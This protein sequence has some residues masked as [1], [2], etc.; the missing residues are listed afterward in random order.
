MILA[1]DVGGT[2]TLLGLFERGPHRPTRTAVGSFPTA[3]FGSLGDI[4]SAFL[5]AEGRSAD[6]LEGACFGVAGPVVEGRAV[7]TNVG[8]AVMDADLRGGLGLDRVRLLND[9]EAT[10]WSLPVLAPLEFETLQDG[11]P[12]PHGNLAIIAAG[13]GLG[14]AIVLRQGETYQPIASEG[15]HADFAPATEREMAL[16]ESLNVG[17][18]RVQWEDI[19]SGRGLVTLHRFT[20][21]RPCAAVTT[22]LDAEIAPAAISAAA[23]AHRCAACVEAL[24][25][26]AS[27]YGSAAGNLALTAVATG[28]LYVGGGIAPKV[29][30]VLQG[31]RFMTGFTDRRRMR[32][33]LDGIPVRVILAPEAGLLG[34]ATAALHST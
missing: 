1:G 21:T 7:L 26:F 28:G 25:L 5:G 33:L 9:L 14:M 18:G 19:V 17:G 13:T 6:R 2:K 34:A 8:W 16:L 10:A 32:A 4:I 15:G 30:S 20:H 23:L 27:A 24:D 11:E 31:G 29:L 3:Q 12:T 22:D